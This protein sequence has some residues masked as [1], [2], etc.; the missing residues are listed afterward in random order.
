MGSILTVRRL[1]V[2]REVGSVCFVDQLLQQGGA[3]S[4]PLSL[5][6]DHEYGQV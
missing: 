6:R 1:E 3:C 2:T 4:C 5:G